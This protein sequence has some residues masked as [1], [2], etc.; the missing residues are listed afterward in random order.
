MDKQRTGIQNYQGSDIF[1][2][3]LPLICSYSLFES[4][5]ERERERDGMQPQAGKL[6]PKL[7]STN[8]GS[9]PDSE[10]AYTH[11]IP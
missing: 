1:R 5:G 4:D 7:C 10:V 9:R 6:F 11:S 2:Y 8:Y 3:I